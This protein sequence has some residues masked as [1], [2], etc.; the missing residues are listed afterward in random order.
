MLGVTIGVAAVL[1]MLSMG[2][3][4]KRRI[5][6][7][8]EALGVNKLQIY[9]SRTWRLKAGEAQVGNPFQS[10]S[11]TSDL[12][13]LKGLFPEVALISPVLSSWGPSVEFGGKLFK[14]DLHLYGVNEEYLQISNAK[15]A[16][17]RFFSQI[18]VERNDK[19][20]VLGA[21]FPKQLGT[22]ANRLI[23]EFVMI[24]IQERISA[25]CI[26]VGILKTQGSNKEWFKPD[27]QILMPSK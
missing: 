10:F 16:Y 20:C 5:L 23:G 12:E 7:G 19:V 27:R 11:W 21:D 13:P 25:A 17:G 9:G 26:V 15:V 22:T 6:E 24:K 14:E 18:N 1:A 2:Q 8:Y 4:A 3:F